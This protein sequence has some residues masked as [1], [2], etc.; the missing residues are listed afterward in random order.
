MDVID[1]AQQQEQWLRDQA[2]AARATAAPAGPSATHC[3]DC[4]VEIPAARREAV[5]GVQFC[6]ACQELQEVRRGR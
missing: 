4:D 2:L 5:P 3:A 1:R 6:V